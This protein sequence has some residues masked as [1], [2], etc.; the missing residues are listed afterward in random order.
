MKWIQPTKFRNINF[1]MSYNFKNVT[2]EIDM[3]ITKN[4]WKHIPFITRI[5]TNNFLKPF[6]NRYVHSI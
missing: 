1:C 4:N 2:K 3:N 5:T 6:S